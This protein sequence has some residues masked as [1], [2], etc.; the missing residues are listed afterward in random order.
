MSNLRKDI[1]WGSLFW[2]ALMIVYHVFIAPVQMI[3]PTIAF[4]GAIGAVVFRRVATKEDTV[5][6]IAAACLGLLIAIFWPR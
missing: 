5:K 3:W 2:A 6:L 4:L 1:F